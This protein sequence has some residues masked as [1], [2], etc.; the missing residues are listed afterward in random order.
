MG[1][2]YAQNYSHYDKLETEPGDLTR[3][4]LQIGID[5]EGTREQAHYT[6]KMPI[7]SPAA[8]LPNAMPGPV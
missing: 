3:P 1:T 2:S 4:Q 5:N 7:A 8:G 6:G